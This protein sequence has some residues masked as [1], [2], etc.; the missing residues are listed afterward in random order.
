MS[1]KDI[2]TKFPNISESTSNMVLD[3]MKETNNAIL[4]TYQTSNPIYD[5]ANATDVTMS[6]VRHLM[7]FDTI[8]RMSTVMKLLKACDKVLSIK[9]SSGIIHEPHVETFLKESMHEKGY[10]NLEM[11]R[12]SGMGRSDIARLGLYDVSLATA[13]AVADV[14]EMTIVVEDAK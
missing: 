9:D 12:L 6:K 5:A 2:F 1:N 8:P 7:N 4:V 11:E 10:S 14:M 3:V 13:C